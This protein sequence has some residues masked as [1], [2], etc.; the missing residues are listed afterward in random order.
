M[1]A[2]SRSTSSAAMRRRQGPP[3]SWR[4]VRPRRVDGWRW[5]VCSMCIPSTRF[6]WDWRNLKTLNLPRQG[7]PAAAKLNPPPA[8]KPKG[9]KKADRAEIVITPHSP[10]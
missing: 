6:H 5:G 9:G 8:K 7:K 3:R 10:K 1:V 2:T 4:P